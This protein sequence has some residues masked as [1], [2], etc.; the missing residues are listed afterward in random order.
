MSKKKSPEEKAAFI[1]MG[2][3]IADLR[4]DRGLSNPDL[5]LKAKVA[6]ST[7]IQ[8]ELGEVNTKWGTLRKLATGLQVPLDA[9]VARADELTPGVGR[10][11]RS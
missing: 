6:E 7:L 11:P 8:I 5:A 9:L 10:R 2:L 1:G 3:A 4:E